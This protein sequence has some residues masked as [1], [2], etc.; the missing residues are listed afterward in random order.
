[1]LFFRLVSGISIRFWFWTGEC[2]EPFGWE[3]DAIPAACT[4]MDSGQERIDENMAQEFNSDAVP[5]GHLGTAFHHR[6]GMGG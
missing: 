2:L 1:M 6:T 4:T 5:D 3:N